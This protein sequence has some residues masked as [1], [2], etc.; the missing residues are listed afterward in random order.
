M[1][2][3]QQ[4]LASRVARPQLRLYRDV[5]YWLFLV[6]AIVGSVAGAIV[7]L[8]SSPSFPLV[9]LLIGA[10]QVAVFVCLLWL[11]VRRLKI[12]VGTP[13]RLIAMAVWWGMSAGVMLA[14][15]VGSNSALSVAQKLGWYKVQ[16]SFGGALPEETTKALGIWLLLW[17]GRAWWNRP[18]HG[19]IAGMF[20][21][22]GFEL[23]EN[24]L[25]AVSGSI[26]NP[27]ND[28]AGA[29]EIL[30]S[31]IL[32]GFSLH[33][34]FSALVGYGLGRAMYEGA[35]ASGEPRGTAWRLG[36]ILL[37][38]GLGFV[39][40]FLWNV[41]WPAASSM[42]IQIVIWALDVAVMVTIIVMNERRVK[43]LM[44]AAARSVGGVPKN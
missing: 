38:G 40:H 30:G 7:L 1:T 13:A 19:V 15:L 26:L 2:Y 43:R 37:W 36:Q 14:V 32:F 17:I 6:L 44:R 28:V 9:Q 34:I 42:F 12:F 23:Y 5:N 10:V 3:P 33:L 24:M 22:L 29:V 16:A 35:R 8:T 39:T 27:A 4:S 41:S 20:V 25:Y 31:R 18:W 21:G 11:A